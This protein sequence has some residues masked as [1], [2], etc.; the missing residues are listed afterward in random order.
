MIGRKLVFARSRHR[1]D[2]GLAGERLLDIAHDKIRHVGAGLYGCRALMRRQH[3]IVERDESF[4]NVR[5]VLKNVKRSA[6]NAVLLQG[7]NKGIGVD[8][9]AAGDVDEIPLRAERIEH[10]SINQVMRF[11]ASRND[12]DEEVALLSQGFHVGETLPRDV[13]G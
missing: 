2:N 3:N 5:F 4:F 10:F 9:R 12:Y 13:L 7:F 11:G 8:K 1:V 6:G